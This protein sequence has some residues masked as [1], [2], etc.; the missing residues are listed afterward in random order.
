MTTTT[1]N[2]NDDALA[3]WRLEARGFIDYIVT[4]AV[5][6]VSG[7]ADEKALEAFREFHDQEVPLLQ[8]LFGLLGRL[9]MR[10]DRPGYPLFQAQYN[11]CT[12]ETL[13]R[14][15]IRMVDA[16]VGAM[17]V[18]LDRWSDL[19]EGGALEERLLKGLLEEWIK[20]RESSRKTIEKVL[21]AADRARA[22]AAG[23]EVEEIVEE[24]AE[25]DDEFPWHDEA[26]ELDARMKL[27]EG[28]GLFEKLFAAMAQTDCTAC[29]YDCEGYARA[30]ADGEDDDL[31]KCAPGESE[32][33]EMLQ[34]L[35]GK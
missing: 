5:P 31:T 3:L 14:V 9:G 19:D 8:R 18:M 23:E 20:L 2:I 6:T 7:E 34:K 11:F 1:R 33:L 32:T 25:G 21:S 16:E 13:A 17:Q 29:G 4:V 10:A 22:E 12:T 15:F 28:K 27:V 30:I 35:M 26:L 24:A